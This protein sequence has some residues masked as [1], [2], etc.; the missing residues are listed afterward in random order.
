[1]RIG[2]LQLERDADAGD[3][4]LLHASRHGLG[5]RPQD[6]TQ[7]VGIEQVLARISHRG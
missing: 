4:G 1:M 7:L 5:E 3:A 6:G 2:G